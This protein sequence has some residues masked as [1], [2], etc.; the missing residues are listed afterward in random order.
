MRLLDAIILD[1]VPDFDFSEKNIYR[2]NQIIGN[3]GAK[4][5]PNYFNSIDS[6]TGFLMFLIKEACE[7]CGLLEGFETPHR[8][9][10]Q[11][12]FASQML[13]ETQEKIEE[14]GTKFNILN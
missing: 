4:I 3:N 9:Y 11:A 12:E 13:K 10:K 5:S 6:A 14:L 1:S 2:L 7:Y 8:K